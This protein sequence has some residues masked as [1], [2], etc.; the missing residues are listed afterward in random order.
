LPGLARSGGGSD[1]HSPDVLVVADCNSVGVHGMVGC[2]AGGERSST[3]R[4]RSQRRPVDGA[5][6]V[7]EAGK[8]QRA[9][10][11][12]L[13]GAP[14]GGLS[15]ERRHGSSPHRRQRSG[16]HAESLRDHSSP[17]GQSSWRRRAHLGT[18]E[19]RR[20]PR[21]FAPRGRNAVDGSFA[22]RSYGR[23]AVAARC[24]R[25]RQ[26]RRRVSAKRR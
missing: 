11:R 25:E 4:S 9:C 22:Q 15:L 16:E 13:D 18:A 26:R 8:R 10:S 3:G 23:C 5:R 19:R 17:A 21:S 2:R 24:G 7:G 12:R 14:V 20:R 1:A 6:V